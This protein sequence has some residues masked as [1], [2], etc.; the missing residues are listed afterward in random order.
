M[1]NEGGDM[2]SIVGSIYLAYFF[3]HSR[4]YKIQNPVP[5]I[6]FPLED[7]PLRNDVNNFLK[8]LGIEASN[9]ITLVKSNEGCFCDI[10]TAKLVL[11]DHN[12]LIDAQQ[13]GCNNVIGVVDHHFDE[14]LYVDQ[15][16]DLRIIRTV[17]SASTLVAELYRD[18]DMTVPCPILLSAP[19]I[20]D[21]VN[22]EPAQKKVTPADVSVYEWLEKGFTEKIDPKALHKKL[23]KWKNDVLSLTVEQNLKRDY[24]NFNY[25]VHVLKKKLSTGI[26]SVPCSYFEFEEAYTLDG[27]FNSCQKY[28]KDKDLESIIIA[29]AGKRNGVHSRQIAFFAPNDAMNCFLSYARSEPSNIKFTEIG[30]KESTPFSLIAFSL[31]DPAV[32]RKRLAP[33]LAAF[34]EKGESSL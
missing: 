2:D 26:S 32:S 14:Q 22:F 9:L 5:A 15:T 7:L 27:I 24:K 6:N 1:G 8:E 23:S 29:F 31:S 3:E 19:I 33:S 25:D 10:N 12:K 4:K 30:K 13:C 28:Y 21:T 20:Q 18:E 16:K 17:G 34:L 11:Y